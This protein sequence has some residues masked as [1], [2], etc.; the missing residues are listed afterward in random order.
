MSWRKPTSSI[1]YQAYVQPVTEKHVKLDCYTQGNWPCLS[2][3]ETKEIPQCQEIDQTPGLGNLG[4]TKI[5]VLSPLCLS[6]P[7]FLCP[8]VPSHLHPSVP[9]SPSPY[10]LH[11]TLCLC[12]FTKY[13]TETWFRAKSAYKWMWSRHHTF[14]QYNNGQYHYYPP[15][16]ISK[17]CPS[18]LSLPQQDSKLSLLYHVPH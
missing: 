18:V 12:S 14:D 15:S 4:R 10:L 5:W 9:L 11:L 8:S 13:I 2:G 6:V 16:L 1:W 3:D 17:D 7:S